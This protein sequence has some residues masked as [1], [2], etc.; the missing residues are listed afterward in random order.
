MGAAARLDRAP[1]LALLILT[2]LFV[3]LAAL[4]TP[5][6]VPGADA[7]RAAA[8]EFFTPEQIARSEA[9][10]NDRKWIG[11]LSWA[12]S[13]LFAVLVG[14][15]RLGR[16]LVA[17]V[18]RR[19][20]RWWLQVV[21]LVVLVS[22]VQRLVSL[23]LA[24]WYRTVLLDY[25]LATDTWWEWTVDLLKAWAI[26]T[27]L[28]V[29]AMLAL[30][31]LARRF[32]RGWYIPAALGAALLV[33]VMSF[34]YPVV[35]APAFNTFIPMQD[36]ALRTR[37]VAMAEQDGI[38][39]S[40]VLIADASRRTTTLNAYVAGF[41]ATKR[42]VV[43]DNLLAE[44][45]D[46]EV[47]VLVAHELG[48]AKYDDVLVGTIQGAV[49]AAIAM[50]ALYLLLRA[51]W[52]RRPLGVRS[53]GDP[54]VV[55]V[56]MALAVLGGALATPI[57]NTLSRQVEAR[58]D[59]HSLDLSRDPGTFITMQHRLAVANISHLTPNPVLS[60]WFNSHPTTLDR[61]GMAVEWAVEHDVAVEEP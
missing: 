45:S 22:V 44:A 2:G 28:T 16:W 60:F 17:V 52:V 41:G 20:G 25:G 53:A 36:S 57:Q 49:G 21:A 34:L 48:H 1:W 33:V 9:F 12:V 29:L 26:F 42:I 30:V 18:G 39:V 8:A 31:G 14:F 55:P 35:F 3:A 37:L 51:A 27:G 13:I 43:Y 32:V 50:V 46:D 11:W 15:S 56:V 54:A 6:D 61:I 58:A 24:A 23:P 59:A 5:W 38:E 40:E 7:P 47:E 4:W 19:T 10:Y